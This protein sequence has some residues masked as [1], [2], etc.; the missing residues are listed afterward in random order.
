MNKAGPGRG[1]LRDC[2]SAGL[3]WGKARRYRV[4]CLPVFPSAHYARNVSAALRAP[5]TPTPHRDPPWNHTYTV[6][7]CT[8]FP[9]GSALA[10][11]GELTGN[12]QTHPARGRPSACAMRPRQR[13]VDRCS[14]AQV[15][16]TSF[17]CLASRARF[18]GRCTRP[19]CRSAWSRGRRPREGG[20]H[21]DAP[22]PCCLHPCTHPR[23]FPPPPPPVPPQRG[24]QRGRFPLGGSRFGAMFGAT[25]IP[26]HH[27]FSSQRH[28]WLMHRESARTPAGLA[29]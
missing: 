20:Y 17:C 13:S 28:R 26:P 18:R 8:H 15:A 12:T 7:S 5:Q 23:R 10:G 9:H 1:R 16:C 21:L 24:R 19:T 11:T 27:F 6:T 25:T 22:H 3:D 29:R 2:R 14:S 4:R